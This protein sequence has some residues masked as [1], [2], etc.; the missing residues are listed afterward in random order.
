MW[1]AVQSRQGT[2]VPPLAWNPLNRGICETSITYSHPVIQL[3]ARRA[4]YCW[5]QQGRPPKARSEIGEAGR[6]LLFLQ[7]WEGTQE[8]G[9]QLSSPQKKSLHL[10]CR[11]YATM[12]S[13]V[14]SIGK[15]LVETTFSVETWKSIK[16]P[17]LQVFRKSY[18]T[19][20]GLSI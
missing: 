11:L 5:P 1:V 12:S 8:Q 15:Y 20:G 16:E 9:Q 17:Y 6:N 7:S 13:S 10:K 18:S 19:S 4:V 2:V 14:N 3:D